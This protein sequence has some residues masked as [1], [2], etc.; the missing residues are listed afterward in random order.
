MY[1]SPTKR[2][3]KHSKVIE[4][5]DDHIF[6]EK[7]IKLCISVLN[8]IENQKNYKI[9]NELNKIKDKLIWYSKEGNL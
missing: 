7:L 2:R 3:Y 5:K 8:Y 6:D 1:I 9:S 4:K